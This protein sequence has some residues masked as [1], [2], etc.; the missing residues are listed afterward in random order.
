MKTADER[1]FYF[2][3]ERCG[4]DSNVE[5]FLLDGDY[6]DCYPCPDCQP[7]RDVETPMTFRL[8]G[9]GASSSCSK[10]VRRSDTSSRQSLFSP[11]FDLLKDEIH[12]LFE[13]TAAAYQCRIEGA[14]LSDRFWELAL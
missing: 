3:C 1:W 4:R 7:D 9:A 8:G 2:Y 6:S 14:K 13:I 10:R 5:G 11:L 12:V